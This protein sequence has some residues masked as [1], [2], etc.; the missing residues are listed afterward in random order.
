MQLHRNSFIIKPSSNITKQFSNLENKQEDTLK[1]VGSKL[2]NA[3]GIDTEFK[4]QEEKSGR[5]I[6]PIIIESDDTAI[7]QL[8]WEL[9]YHPKFGFLAKDPRFTLSRSISKTP[10]LDVSLEKS[11]LRILYFSTLPDDLKESERLAVENEQVAVLESLLPFIKEGLVELQI[12]YDG[13][14]ES[15]DRY[16]KRFEPHLVF[17]SGHGIY[18]K[19]VGYFLFEDKRGLRVEINEQRLTL[20]FNGSTVECV[21][22]SSCQSAKTESDELNNGLARALAF[23]G[24]KNVIG[25]SESIYEQAGTS[26]VENFMK[27]LS[28]KNA[29]S[30]A[31]QE[32]R[33]EI[34][35]LEGVVSSHWFLPLLISQDISTPLIDW[36]FTP[37]IPSREMTNQKLNQIIFPKLFIGRRCEFREFYNYLYG[38]ELKKLLI[39]GEGGIGKS[40]LAGKFG[41][42]LRHEG[43]KVFDYSLKHG[44]DFDSFL[45]DVEFSLSKERQET[46][47][48]I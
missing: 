46:Y 8:P 27:V 37:K 43:Y 23:E 28:G 40:A 9:L 42:E 18:D 11:P 47:K 45:M 38:K 33:K 39:Y 36:S 3:L 16:I 30:I 2:W 26:F 1:A 4:D 6:L 34:S 20:A 44:D 35:K 22:L 48:N 32:A 25:M 15:L 14:F 31:L 13:R 10:K 21:V 12:P 19:G 5:E 7:L 17:L 29:I 24:I 41:L